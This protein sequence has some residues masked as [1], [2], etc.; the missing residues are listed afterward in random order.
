VKEKIRSPK[1]FIQIPLLVGVIVFIIVASGVSYGLVEYNK[2]SKII[3]KADQLSQ[4]EKYN[5]AIELL[6]KIQNKW[7]VKELGVKK[8]VITEKLERNKRFLEEKLN[9]TQGIE[10]FNKGNWEKA[11]E[12]LSKV[13]Q[14]FPYYQE[15]KNKLEEI[16]EK[17]TEKKIAEAV[18]EATE[19]IKKEAEEARKAAQK[20]QEEIAQE[21]KKR[22]IEKE[23]AEEKITELEQTISELQQQKIKEEEIKELQKYAISTAVAR[24]VCFQY[25]S[26]KNISLEA[27]GSIWYHENHYWVLTNDHVL[28]EPFINGDYCIVIIIKDWV[29]AN[30]NFEKALQE[31]KVLVYEIDLSN[32]FYSPTSG[33]D[34]AAAL[35]KKIPE[36]DQPLY[37]LE[38][39]AL[40]PNPE[41]CNQT[42][43]V[44]TPIKI[45]GYPSIGSL[46]ITITDGIISSFEKR[47]EVYYYLVSAKV[48]EGSSGGLAVTEDFYCV[49]GIPTY[50]KAGK[51]EALGRVLTLTEEDILDF[52]PSLNP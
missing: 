10:E 43:S 48:E 7:L 34:L 38:E 36:S 16:Q 22:E 9:F 12:L 39:I 14:D 27:S 28:E 49:V 24:I 37:L 26:F 35:L 45:L 52:L 15:V 29:A 46:I 3:K 42:Y 11:K 5:E 20:A 4:E 8:Q 41:E 2:T 13:S 1:S 6:E 33:N 23:K 17:I 25:P 51:Y 44:G 21:R 19:K 30:E 50:L 47:G 32:Y 18:K 31:N 40:I